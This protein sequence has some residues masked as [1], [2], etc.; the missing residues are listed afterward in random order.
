MVKDFGCGFFPLRSIIAKVP[1]ALP[2]TLT[3]RAGFSVGAKQGLGKGALPLFELKTI[4]FKAVGFVEGCG[5]F[6]SSGKP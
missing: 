3:G 4:A 5:F 6:K 1:W 2:A